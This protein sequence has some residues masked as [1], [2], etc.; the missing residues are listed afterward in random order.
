MVERALVDLLDVFKGEFNN[1]NGIIYPEQL[2]YFNGVASSL[3]VDSDGHILP[4]SITEHLKKVF[5]KK[6]DTIQH[7]S[8]ILESLILSHACFSFSDIVP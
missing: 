3:K 2:G 8:S 1:S 7:N 4:S 6:E 5:S